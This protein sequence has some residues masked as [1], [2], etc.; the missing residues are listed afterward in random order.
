MSR[1]A[2]DGEGEGAEHEARLGYYFHEIEN[3]RKH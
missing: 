1:V 3:K 2:H